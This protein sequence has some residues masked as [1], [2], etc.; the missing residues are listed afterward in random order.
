MIKCHFVLK[1]HEKGKALQNN[2]LA[3]N[4]KDESD[5][6]ARGSL[7]KAETTA[8][9]ALGENGCFSCDLRR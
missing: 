9:S 3:E 4:H 8:I 6:R 2:Y 1:Q 7:S 5:V